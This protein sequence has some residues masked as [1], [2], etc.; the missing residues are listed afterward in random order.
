[1]NKLRLQPVLLG[2]LV[3]GV[4][5]ALPIISIANC[6]CLW[7]VGGGAIAAYLSQQQSPTTL[8]V[9]D[10]ALAGLLAGLVG[11]GVWLVVSTPIHLIMYPLQQ[12]MFSQMLGQGADIPEPMR[13]W[14]DTFRSGTFTIIQTAIGFFVMLVV[15][16]IFSGIG[17]ALGIAIF[18]HRQQPPAA[19]P[20]APP[21]A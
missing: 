4:L 3:I 5:S 20:D 12:R 7:I 17:G 8:S 15:G 13:M 1:M 6:C 11:A 16:T 2:G 21:Q 9:G 10:G 19:T 18:G 14:A